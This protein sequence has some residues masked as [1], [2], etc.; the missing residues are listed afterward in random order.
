MGAGVP[1]ILSSAKNPEILRVVPEKGGRFCF[2]FNL[3]DGCKDARPGEKC[4]R[5][6]HLCP[7]RG[8]QLPHCYAREHPDG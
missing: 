4:N 5:G 2:P 8:C 7:K 6:W 1:D 3:K